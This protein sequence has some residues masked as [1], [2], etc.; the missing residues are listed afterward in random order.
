MHQ[1]L[2]LDNEENTA[3]KSIECMHIQCDN[4][5]VDDACLDKEEMLSAQK[6]VEN[7]LFLSLVAFNQA[8]TVKICLR[9]L[10]YSQYCIDESLLYCTV[11]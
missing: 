4:V 6:N 7:L 1:D 8:S 5:Q 11:C 10:I 9:L 2:C 3:K